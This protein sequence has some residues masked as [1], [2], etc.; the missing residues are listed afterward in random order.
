MSNGNPLE[1]REQQEGAETEIK[2]LRL[3]QL[4]GGPHQRLCAIFPFFPAAC[5]VS[6]SV[7][8]CV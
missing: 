5:C 7:S 8:L 4:L 3:R 2:W 1:G 6:V